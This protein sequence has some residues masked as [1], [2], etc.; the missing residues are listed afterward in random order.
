MFTN[1]QL[2][3]AI[4]LLAEKKQLS[5]AGLARAAGLDVT[6]FNFSKRKAPDGRDR[7]PSTA[8]LSKVLMATG[9]P[10]EEFTALLNKSSGKTVPVGRTI[11]LIGLA[12]A[13]TGGFF[14]DAGFPVGGGWEEISFPHIEDENAYAL[15][16]SGDSMEP[17]YRQ[18]DILIV[19]PNANCRRGDRVVAKT[20]SG[21]VLFK[22]LKRQT[23]RTVE[24]SSFNP[25]HDDLTFE[26]EEMDWIAR[27]LWV[28][29]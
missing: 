16:V 4:D 13:G 5:L 17:V 18:G 7:W 24:L 27:V 15:E 11:P 2:W 26:L 14:D 29:Q 8:S 9:T 20:F 12:Q 6:I 23:A 10:I 28:S 19:G 21:Q 22:I 1:K 3:N 25:D